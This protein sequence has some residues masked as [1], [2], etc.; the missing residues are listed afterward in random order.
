M[1]KML[2]V[3]EKTGSVSVVS[4]QAVALAEDCIYCTD[5]LGGRGKPVQIRQDR[6]L[7]WDGDVQAMQL[8][9]AH[10]S[11]QVRQPLPPIRSWQYRKQAVFTVQTH[12]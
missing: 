12:C 6:L 9:M 5:G 4:Q 2:Q 3:G 1:E 8:A 11:Q 10:L 7:V